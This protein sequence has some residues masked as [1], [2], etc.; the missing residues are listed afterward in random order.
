MAQGV[1]PAWN[2]LD[3]PGGPIGPNPG[4]WDPFVPPIPPTIDPPAAS[5]SP[6]GADLSLIDG[7][8]G[9]FNPA[10]WQDVDGF[11]PTPTEFASGIAIDRNLAI[12]GL[13]VNWANFPQGDDVNLGSGSLS[14]SFGSYDAG[15]PFGLIDPLVAE[16]GVRGTGG[17]GATLS[18]QQAT[19]SGNYF[20]NLDISV[21]TG[22]LTL[23]ALSADHASGSAIA[24]S[25]IDLTGDAIVDL[26]F[27]DATSF[28][29]ASLGTTL[30]TYLGLL[31]VE[32][33]PPVMGSDPTVWETGDT[34]AAEP[35]IQQQL[36][37][38]TSEV[39]DEWVG[40]WQLTTI[41]EPSAL[42]LAVLGAAGLL[43]RSRRGCR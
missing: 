12:M 27:V 40:G 1:R 31:A 5:S 19:L 16:G 43:R 18:L 25:T 20:Q 36:D 35:I 7:S 8:G 34:L 3:F 10:G 14:L 28:S 29:P 23:W 41:P 6:A 4:T 22:Q 9:F 26:M 17:G 15:G 24:G 42:V 21:A 30:T 11:S 2:P 38:V 33:M 37:P 32:G 13:G 39:V